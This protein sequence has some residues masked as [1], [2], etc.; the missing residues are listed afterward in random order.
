M[1]TT[2]TKRNAKRP[3]LN[4]PAW[5]ANQLAANCRWAESDAKR[6][7]DFADRAAVSDRE[8][9]TVLGVTIPKYTNR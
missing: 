7:A 3:W 2:T 5:E 9:T 1:K 6:R 4:D 8:M